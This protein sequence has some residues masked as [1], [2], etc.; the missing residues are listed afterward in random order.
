MISTENS[1]QDFDCGRDLKGLADDVCNEVARLLRDY[2]SQSNLIYEETTKLA[3][4]LGS[5]IAHHQRDLSGLSVTIL[6]ITNIPV[7]DGDLQYHSANL[8]STIKPSVPVLVFPRGQTE[9]TFKNNAFPSLERADQ[10]NT[11]V[12][13]EKSLRSQLLRAQS[14]PHQSTVFQLQTPHTSLNQVPTNQIPSPNTTPSTAPRLVRSRSFDVQSTLD[15]PV[16]LG[17][18]TSQLSTARLFSPSSAS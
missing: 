15:E 5:L 6:P 17:S 1:S 8:V 18:S 3:V 2:P 12:C 14:E 16:V 13:K 9:N 7:P 4:A 10:P 11:I